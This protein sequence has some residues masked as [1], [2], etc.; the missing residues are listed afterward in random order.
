ME[1]H[2][3][4][5]FLSVA[6]SGGL[7]L[8]LSHFN[9]WSFNYAEA[10]T[11]G[12]GLSAVADSPEAHDLAA[13]K[14]LSRVIEQV[15]NN[16][17]DTNRVKP[18]EMFKASLDY[19]SK[20]TAEIML[21]PD[22][23]DSFTLYVDTQKQSFSTKQISGLTDLKFALKDVFAFLVK[24]LPKGTNLR[25]IEYNAVNGLL[26]TLDPHTVLMKPDLFAEMRTTTKGEFGGLGI[27]IGL[28]DGGLTVV[29]PMSGTPAA[30]A[31]I[32][33][34]DKIIKIDDES[35]VNMDT[36][37]AVD[38]LRGSV[39]T[40]VTITLLRKGWSEPKDF[41]ITRAVI[42]LESVTAQT[43]SDNV[44]YVK[45][46]NFQGNTYDDLRVA[47]NSFQKKGVTKGLVLDLRDNPGGLLEQSIK[48]SDA[49]LTQGQIV[50]TVGKQ[51][52]RPL[53]ED[54][55]ATNSRDEWQY[56]VVVLI[57]GG[58]ASA[59]EIVSGALKNDDR[60]LIVGTQSFGKGSVQVLYDFP[61]QS[62]LKLTIAQYLTPGDVSIQNVG[63]TPD[64]M[65]LPAVI[66]PER[67]T[68][69][70]SESLTKESD[71]DSH[72]TS[73][74]VAKPEEPA[75]KIHYFIDPRFEENAKKA[76]EENANAFIEDPEIV[77]AKK[78]MLNAQGKTRKDLLRLSDS[79][80][81][82]FAKEQEAQISSALKTQGVDWAE[83]K[84]LSNNGAA[85]ATV[86]FEKAGTT[87]QAGD[88]TKLTLTVK[89]TGAR[90]LYRLRAQTKS[91]S[92]LFDG[93][94]LFVGKLEP[95]AS[96]SYTLPIKVPKEAIS[97]TDD[98]TYTFF[99]DGNSVPVP[100]TQT[101]QVKGLERPSFAYGYRIV[102]DEGGN[103]NGLAEVGES[104]KL[105]LTVKNNGKGKSFETVTALKSLAGK[106]I[107]LKDG[108]TNI[109][110]I[111]PNEQKTAVFT[112][113]VRAKPEKGDSYLLEV[114]IADLTLRE[115]LGEKLLIPLYEKAPIVTLE[116]I[117]LSVTTEGAALYSGAQEKTPIISTFSK[118][119]QFTAKGRVGDFYKVSLADGT[120]G[121]IKTNQVKSATVK[122]EKVKSKAKLQNSPPI[123]S[124]NIASGLST[125]NTSLKFGGIVTDDF[126]IHDM[127]ILVNGKKV[128]Y[129]ANAA[130]NT[131]LKYNTDLPLD[132]GSNT[133]VVVARENDDVT[134][135]ERL[136]IRREK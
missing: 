24:A 3:K 16:Y 124:M 76:L 48:I 112:F 41:T 87:L 47:L 72:L 90:D 45:I 42:K 104:I 4:P 96:K 63:I 25:D 111:A 35:T 98:V 61:D 64:I 30:K 15:S 26:S 32:K 79:F 73:E 31:G 51:N 86:S 100:I 80:N 125:K 53:R 56:P 129:Q 105:V 54:R 131:E 85:T 135:Q 52:G 44:G 82:D 106:S 92:P 97:R 101:V 108:R 102:D 114:S 8:W 91:D 103:G 6:M 99:E 77:F 81:V 60:A 19:L 122:I 14:V 126:N 36:D 116:S 34:Q 21:Q 93:L 123:I 38:R 78:L 27:Q 94:E 68:Y 49:F 62:A 121:F 127:Y 117:G 115:Y 130:T 74:F 119:S 136:I 22:G 71:L 46:K 109:D 37:D 66:T 84:S 70:T 9:G 132:L 5:L 43:L 11:P 18:K 69:F 67:I 40:D 10:K 58:S 2:W 33:A 20:T 134:S 1:K 88:E 23:A 7:Y 39:G 17:V 83:G 57:N 75:V 128:F 118:G 110:N 55:P 113:D 65:L 107:L 50:S 95:G 120:S 29:A 133:I 12:G 59:S 13:G 89:N 28:R